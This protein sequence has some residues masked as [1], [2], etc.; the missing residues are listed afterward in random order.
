MRFTNSIKS[1]ST[2]RIARQL[3]T[4]KKRRKSKAPKPSSKSL[5][6]SS[7]NV[8]P[9]APISKVLTSPK[10]Q[11]QAFNKLVDFQK[12]VQSFLTPE[13]MKDRPA[14]AERE[15]VGPVMDH[16]WWL[17][18]LALACVPGLMVAAICKFYE[19]DMEDFY[20][21]QKLL[22]ENKANGVPMNVDENEITRSAPPGDDEE[23][24]VWARRRT[25]VWNAAMDIFGFQSK[26]E[27]DEENQ[28]RV[29]TND[30]GEITQ[31][32][33]NT[34]GDE[35]DAERQSLEGTRTRTIESEATQDSQEQPTMD[36]LIQRIELLE[37]QLEPR[38]QNDTRV[39]SE[40]QLDLSN[41]RNRRNGVPRKIVS[42][43]ANSNTIESKTIQFN[44]DIVKESIKHFLQQKSDD[45]MQRGSEVK[46]S[47]LDKVGDEDSDH[48]EQGAMNKEDDSKLPVS[49]NV[50]ATSKG[51]PNLENKEKV[52]D[53]SNANGEDVLNSDSEAAPRHR[54]WRRIPLLK[55]N[56]KNQNE[57]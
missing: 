17:W 37:K 56:H 53:E 2:L 21:Q 26:M 45:L 41:I 19:G 29:L 15:K 5:S 52:V 43:E 34:R 33:T 49:D 4:K 39:P 12:E 38:N 24:G 23:G 25:S 10:V 36:S 32:A 16:N 6:K 7:K 42:E 27:M 51:A 35:V 1:S 14:F 55:T 9:L 18:N 8:K 57:S 3:S 40:R 28:N 54:W 31:Q 30:D 22:E 44:M 13:F 47:I 46:R 50:T 11:K 20:R 48:V